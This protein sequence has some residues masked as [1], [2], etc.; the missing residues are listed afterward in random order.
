MSG[1]AELAAVMMGNAQR[2]IDMTAANVSNVNTPA[3][4]ARHVFAQILDSR[5]AMPIET[6]LPEHGTGPVSFKQTGNP[7][8]IATDSGA[9]LVMRAGSE[10]RQIRSA[11]LNRAT[12][13]R[14]VDAQG[15]VLQAVGGGDV[16]V[17]AGPLA[18]LKDGT[19]LVGGQPEAR[20]G[21]FRP[22]DA[23]IMA[24]SLSLPD[25]V[26]DGVLHQGMVVPSNVDLS[27]EMVELNRASRMAETGAKVFQLY[28]DLTGRA[29]SMLGDIRK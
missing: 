18:I 5:I 24:P 27:T 20:I 8:D 12:D 14:L 21:L 16:I 28:D 26:Q 13:G 25:P 2:R 3:Y 23:G 19:L 11:Q 4:R 9:V 7:L 15:G 29:A 1:L 22:T 10:F 17:G 6:E